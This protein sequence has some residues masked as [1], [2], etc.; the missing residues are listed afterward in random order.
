MEY[1]KRFVVVC[2]QGEQGEPGVKGDKGDRGLP[3]K[4]VS[5]FLTVSFCL[6]RYS[7]STMRL[8]IK[9]TE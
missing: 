2:L 6:P 9:A 8:Y 1:K 7:V 5:R 3:G 4:N